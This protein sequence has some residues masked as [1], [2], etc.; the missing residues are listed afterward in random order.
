VA[1][2]TALVALFLIVG[3][4]TEVAARRRRPSG[5]A[6]GP[7]T[8]ATSA[9][10][11]CKGYSS[12]SSS[13][14]LRVLKRGGVPSWRVD[15]LDPTA[16]GT[17]ASD[18]AGHHGVG[19]AVVVFAIVSSF[20]FGYWRQ[21]SV[22]AAEQQALLAA[23]SVR[24]AVEAGLTAGDR[25]GPGGPS[26][27]WCSSS[28]SWGPG[29]T[30]PRRDPGLERPGRR[31]G[32]GR[33]GCGSPHPAIF[34]QGGPPAGPD[35]ELVNA[36]LP[37]RA[38]GAAILQVDFSLAPLQA[39]MDRAARLGLMLL[40]GSL[41]AVIFIVATMLEREVVTPIERVAGILVPRARS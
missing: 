28:P 16:S 14:V 30:A 25:A 34:P 13:E 12:V 10:I 5:V 7:T 22:A 8:P 3:N 26:R 24:S 9:Y 2:A 21:E 31:R 32:R 11:D 19:T 40:V 1:H 27:S 41:A 6:V 38:G 37:L 35:G 18:Q 20:T 15:G 36:F 4:L 17:A 29:C 23:A 33:W 39:A